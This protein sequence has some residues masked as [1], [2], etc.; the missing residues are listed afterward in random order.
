MS[1]TGTSNPFPILHAPLFCLRIWP[2]CHG[3]TANIAAVPPSSW[4]ILPSTADYGST[5]REAEDALSA[6]TARTLEKPQGPNMLPIRHHPH[7]GKISCAY[8]R[9]ISAYCC[10]P[11][12]KF[13]IFAVALFLQV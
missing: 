1:Q 6:N 9:P 3:H 4:P 2:L 12:K 13:Q 8:G 5:P 10:S 11:F 7:G